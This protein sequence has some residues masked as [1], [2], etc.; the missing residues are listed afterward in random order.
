M[1]LSKSEIPEPTPYRA[2]SA[3]TCLAAYPMTRI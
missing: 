3:L 2:N 1:G